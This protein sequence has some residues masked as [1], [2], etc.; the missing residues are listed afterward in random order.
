[1]P[2]PQGESGSPTRVRLR[3]VAAR[4]G[5]DISTVSRALNDDPGLSIRPATRRRIF[6]AAAEL[7]Y[8][9]NS[10]ARTLKTARTMAL[11]L[12]V[13]DLNNVVYA[14]VTEGAEERA[15]AS[16]Y[17]LVVA[18][19]SMAERVPMLEGRVDGLLVATATSDTAAALSMIER[20]PVVLVNRRESGSIPSVTVD[21]EAGAVMATSYL[22]SLGHREIAHI[23]GPQNTDTA[24]RRKNGFLSAMR[25]HSLQVEHRWVV[26]AP[27]SESGGYAAA[28]RILAGER[29]PTALFATNL[30]TT[31]GAMAA[32][33]RTGLRIP[34]DVSI[35][36]YEDAPLAVFLDPPLTTVRMP[37]REMGTQAVD[38]L[39]SK[40][41]GD[42]DVG[43]LMLD[44]PPELILRASAA[45]PA[46]LT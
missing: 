33:R 40:M 32:I 35:V 12:V 34:D 43:D 3:D 37:L 7:G 10:A 19:G 6:D 26:E 17:V 21:D 42:D 20:T 41:V 5:V 14:S 13:P 15:L 27:Y 39:L 36:G 2:V 1:M 8:R 11:G 44:I 28:L 16:G 25:Q 45:P 9:P 24:R 23:A 18:P 46:A 29:P 31:I 38:L 30:T 4:A 22:I